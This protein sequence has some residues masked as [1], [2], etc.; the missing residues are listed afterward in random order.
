[1][2]TEDI[3]LASFG[4]MNEGWV[5][6]RKYLFA[7]RSKAQSLGVEY[8]RGQIVEFEFSDMMETGFNP[9]RKLKKGLVREMKELKRI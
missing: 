6:P 4:Y 1:M 2:N 7:V 5:D 3:E 8:I 9:V